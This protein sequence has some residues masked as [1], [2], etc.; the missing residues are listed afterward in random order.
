[1]LPKNRHVIGDRVSDAIT[2]ASKNTDEKGITGLIANSKACTGQRMVNSVGGHLR[3]EAKCSRTSEAKAEYGHIL[4]G[5]L[6]NVMRLGQKAIA[7][8]KRGFTISELYKTKE[9]K[10]EAVQ[11]MTRP[12]ELQKILIGLPT[13]RVILVGWQKVS[14]GLE[15]FSVLLV[16]RKDKEVGIWKQLKT[17]QYLDLSP[18]LLMQL[19]SWWKI[20][21]AS[22]YRVAE[23]TEL[24]EECGLGQ[25]T[26]QDLI[27]ASNEGLTEE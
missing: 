26:P 19:K 17:G 14:Y 7:A 6:S 4:R 3:M 11:K 12:E 5:P 16:W 22:F 18:E 20:R 2:R 21:A 27:D 8:D 1:M 13:G 23:G 25:L 10:V 9:I 24:D 15:G